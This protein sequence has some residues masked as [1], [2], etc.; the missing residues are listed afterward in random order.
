MGYIYGTWLE[1]SDYAL[2]DGPSLERYDE[3]FGDG[4]EKSELDILIPVKP[5]TKR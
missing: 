4:D 1:R 3:R 2:A 5:K